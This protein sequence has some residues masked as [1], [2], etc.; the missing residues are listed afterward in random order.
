M[1]KLG[2]I[3]GGTSTEKEVS[4]MSAKSVIE[5]LNKEKYDIYKIFIGPDGKWYNDNNERKEI[6]DLVGTI[7]KLDVIFPVLHGKYG[8]DG[9]IQGLFEMIGVPYVG[10]GVLSSSVGMDK[11]YTKIIF[12]KASINQAPYVYIRKVRG[13][14]KIIN[15][16]F[17]EENLDL[18]KILCLSQQLFQ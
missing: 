17:E 11:V 7:K 14:F 12:E 9:T 13:D 2:V 16:D 4:Q 10:C 8:E 6:T 18:D 5:N 3:Y 1:I 15:A